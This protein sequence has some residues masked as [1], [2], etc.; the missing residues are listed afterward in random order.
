ML[1]FPCSGSISVTAITSVGRNRPTV[2]FRSLCVWRKDLGNWPFS[3]A[4]GL[5][6][7]AQM[8]TTRADRWLWA[9]RVHKTR[10]LATDGC[11]AGHVTV[12]GNQ[13]KAAT[14]VK[15]GDR[16][17]ARVGTRSRDLEVVK[18]IEK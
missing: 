17:V 3:S 5:W 18:I 4:G 8:E 15:P 1:A 7:D 11:R 16:V 14:M 2:R 12:N 10:A 6:D 13:A 9:V